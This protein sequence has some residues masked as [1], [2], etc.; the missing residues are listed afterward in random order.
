MRKIIGGL[1]ENI[2]GG[3]LAVVF[4]YFFLF[5]LDFSDFLDFFRLGNSFGPITLSTEIP[6]S[7]QDKCNAQKISCSVGGTVHDC[8]MRLRSAGR[9]FGFDIGYAASSPCPPIGAT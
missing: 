2:K 8:R 3:A 7:R 4:L 5:S 1:T 9:G 6:Q